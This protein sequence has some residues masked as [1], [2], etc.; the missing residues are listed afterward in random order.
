MGESRLNRDIALRQF[1]RL[2]VWL[3]TVLIQDCAL[4]YAR[5]PLCPIFRFA[6]FTYPSFITF[7]NNATAIINTGEQNACLTFQN[8]PNHMARS[9]HGYATDLQ[10]KQDQNHLQVCEELQKL[11]EQ[12]A[13]LHL[14][15]ASGSP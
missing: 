6:P 15:L 2:L 7:S 12:N 14:M 3:R 5:F 13:Q 1:L 11:R 9:M 8:L 10:M 4:L